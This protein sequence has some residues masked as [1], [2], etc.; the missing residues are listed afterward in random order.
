MTICERKTRFF[1]SLKM[2]NF[3]FHLKKYRRFFFS[4]MTIFVVVIGVGAIS[5][6]CPFWFILFYYLI[7]SKNGKNWN[8]TLQKEQPQEVAPTSKIFLQKMSDNC[9]FL[10]NFEILIFDWFI[11][12][13]LFCVFGFWSQNKFFIWHFYNR[14]ILGRL[15][16]GFDYKLC[17][18]FG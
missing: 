6:G 18:V 7:V 14:K 4:S 5:C 15:I 9:F 11:S 13:D 3:S 1:A 8:I 10:L 17:L 12:K 2:T 16:F